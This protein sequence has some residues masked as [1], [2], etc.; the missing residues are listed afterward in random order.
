LETE[1]T[2]WGWVRTRWARA[3]ETDKTVKTV[4]AVKTVNSL[5]VRRTRES[6]TG[7]TS[8]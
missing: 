7:L 5:E 8:V 6:G 4:E 1:I 3:D 2:C